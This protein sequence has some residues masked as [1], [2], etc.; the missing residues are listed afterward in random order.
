MVATVNNKCCFIPQILI[1]CQ[2]FKMMIVISY[3]DDGKFMNDEPWFLKVL[4]FKH[5]DVNK[6]LASVWTTKSRTSLNHKPHRYET[7]D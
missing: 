6:I 7:I 5:T 2:F 1:H 4:L 3:D